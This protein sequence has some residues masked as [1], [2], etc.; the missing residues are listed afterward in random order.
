M[1]AYEVCYVQ[2]T[3]EKNNNNAIQLS[4]MLSS[5]VRTSARTGKYGQLICVVCMMPSQ[6]R[7]SKKEKLKERGKVN[8]AIRKHYKPAFF[9]F[10]FII[11]WTN[12]FRS[13]LKH[14]LT[15]KCST[16]VQQ[17]VFFS[18]V[19]AGRIQLKCAL[20]K[21]R[22]STTKNLRQFSTKNV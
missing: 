22:M 18:L 6:V 7:V 9:F 16:N 21:Y 10:S 3:D 19:L 17:T 2:F 13:C 15:Q 4:W 5:F 11:T 12:C 20:T 1:V 14:F 8:D